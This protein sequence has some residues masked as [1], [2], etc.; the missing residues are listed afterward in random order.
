MSKYKMFPLS[1]ITCYSF[2]PV[3]VLC[4]FSCRFVLFVW[5]QGLGLLV[6]LWA[7]H[8]PVCV[9]TGTWLAGALWA[10]HRPASPML[11]ARPSTILMQSAKVSGPVVVWLDLLALPF[12]GWACHLECNDVSRAQKLLELST[13]MF[14]P[15]SKRNCSMEASKMC[16]GSNHQCLEEVAHA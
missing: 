15:T 13:S 12:P 1:W 4:L 5:P 8:L 10:A 3:L 11:S 6:L 9:A 7:A 14:S 16:E 2:C